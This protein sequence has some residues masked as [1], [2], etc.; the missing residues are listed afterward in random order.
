MK[1]NPNNESILLSAGY[2]HKVNIIDVRDAAQNI[3]IK[4][5]KSVKD[6]ESGSWHPS[7]EHNFAL[8]TESG[9]VLGYDVRK[10]EKPLW[11]LQSTDESCSGTAFSR[12]IPTMMST[13]GTDGVVRI[14]D[15]AGASPKE[16]GNR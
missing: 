14:W 7:L 1:W 4:V 16:I 3:R 2:D 8:A 13:S 12:H 10:P 6:I 5:S 9:I 11:E 15:I